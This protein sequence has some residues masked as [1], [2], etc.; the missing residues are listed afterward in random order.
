MY[1]ADL[2]LTCATKWQVDNARWYDPALSRFISPDS[3]IPEN[4]GVQA[5]DRF[6]YVSNN[7]LRFTDP[8]GHRNCEEDGYNCPDKNMRLRTYAQAGINSQNPR[9][10]IRGRWWFNFKIDSEE[11]FSGIGPAKVTDRQMETPYGDVVKDGDDRRGIGL[12]F[13]EPGSCTTTSCAIDQ[14]DPSIAIM[15]MEARISLRT[16]ICENNGCTETDIL[17]VSALAQNE[18]IYKDD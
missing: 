12:G 14:V 15:A 7:P 18:S 13:R 6:A 5:L 3:I 9:G 4:Q 2:G 8:T 16:N 10:V 1:T 17:I 11:P